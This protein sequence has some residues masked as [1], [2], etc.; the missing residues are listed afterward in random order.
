MSVDGLIAAALFLVLLALVVF[1]VDKALD[2][3][4]LGH[5]ASDRDDAVAAARKEV[6]ALTTISATSTNRD[7]KRILAGASKSFKAQFQEQATAFRKALSDGQVKSTGTIASAG[8]ASFTGARAQVLVAASGTVQNKTS[9]TA[10]P[11]NYRLKVSLVKT[12]GDWLVSG[13]DF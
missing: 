8:L 12:G 2:V 1:G 11:R 10:Q 13:M 6:L 3:R 7:I 5:T 4:R 9:K